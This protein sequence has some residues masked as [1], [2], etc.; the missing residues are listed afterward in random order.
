MSAIIDTMLSF[1]KRKKPEPAPVC[2]CG[3]WPDPTWTYEMFLKKNELLK[4]C[5]VHKNLQP[6]MVVNRVVEPVPEAPA[7]FDFDKEIRL[8]RIH[9]VNCQQALGYLSNHDLMEDL[10][11]IQDALEGIIEER[12]P[13]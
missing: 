7:V 11:L 12:K 2:N 13:I 5:P 10:E 6:V 9:I 4:N 3:S 8:A 1:L